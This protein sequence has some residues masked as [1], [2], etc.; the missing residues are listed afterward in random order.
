[1]Q[2]LFIILNR[3]GDVIPNNNTYFGE[4]NNTIIL[5]DVACD[6]TEQSLDECEH[7]EPFVTDCDHDED[8]YIECLWPGKYSCI[9][10]ISNFL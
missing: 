8:I 4:S 5:D 3:D 1:M 6:G 2:L 10:L 7:S 9:S